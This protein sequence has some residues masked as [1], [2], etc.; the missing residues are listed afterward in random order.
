MQNVHF[1]GKK[2]KLMMIVIS[3]EPGISWMCTSVNPLKKIKNISEVRNPGSDNDF[4]RKFPK[5]L[6]VQ[7]C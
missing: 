7:D 6:F 1:K 3:L 4:L 5:A 2:K